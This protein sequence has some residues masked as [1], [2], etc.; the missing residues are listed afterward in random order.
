MGPHGLCIGATG[1][2]KS[3]LLRTL[4]IALVATHP[5]DRL[6]VVLVDFKGGATFAELGE[7]PHVAGS[8]TNL[9]DDEALVDRFDVALRSEVQRRQELLRSE[10]GF[11][12]QREYEAARAAGADLGPLPSLLV[13]VDEF[14][15]LLSSRPDLI[16]TFVTIGRLGRSLGIHLLLASQRL[17][18]GRLRGLDSHLSYRI[19]L[20]TFSAGE[21]RTVL[22]VPD[23][24]ELPPVPRSAYPR[25]HTTSP[26]RFRA[27]DGSGGLP[28]RAGA[29]GT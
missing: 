16:D 28:A 29:A 5:P 1:S 3:E 26:V 13:I 2:G 14:S 17:E 19:A 25:H 24:Y 6:N 8:I 12:S 11:T 7:L 4:V 22:G 21:S 18:E 15:E 9:A 20:R 27:A 10:G 23:P